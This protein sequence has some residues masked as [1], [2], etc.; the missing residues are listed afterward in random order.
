MLSENGKNA[1]EP[2]ATALFPSSHALF[3][4][5]VNTGGFSY[6][7]RLDQDGNVVDGIS[8]SQGAEGESPEMIEEEVQDAAGATGEE[9]LETEEQ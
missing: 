8:E 5:L 7:D 2:K 1:S 4:S 6:R 3:S 9:T